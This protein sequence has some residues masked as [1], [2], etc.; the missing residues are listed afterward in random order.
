V[1]RSEKAEGQKRHK[2]M[3][4]TTIASPLLLLRHSGKNVSPPA[5]A[6]VQEYNMDGVPHLKGCSFRHAPIGIQRSTSSSRVPLLNELY[7]QVVLLIW[8]LK[9]AA[10]QEDIEVQWQQKGGSHCFGWEAR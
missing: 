9:I 1:D 5:H 3:S 10:G 6:Q 4:A 7:S 8:G 2:S